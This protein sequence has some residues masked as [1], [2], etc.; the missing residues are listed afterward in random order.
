MK[1][2]IEAALAKLDPENKEH[3]TSTG[4]PR[5]EAVNAILNA[6]KEADQTTEITRQDIQGAAPGFTKDVLVEMLQHGEVV[7]P[8]ELETDKNEALEDETDE[9]ERHDE[10]GDEPDEITEIEQEESLEKVVA[11]PVELP[12]ELKAPKREIPDELYKKLTQELAACDALKARNLK[13]MEQMRLENVET[14]KRKA[15][16]QAERDRLF[17]PM[18]AAQA[19][20][21]YLKRQQEERIKRA[22]NVQNQAAI[23]QSVKSPIDQAMAHRRGLGKNRPNFNPVQTARK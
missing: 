4:L 16:I 21:V 13:A 12:E 22:Q 3:W 19:T 5:V 9:G 15:R 7:D 18:T 1:Q 11:D 6:D 20:Q 23:L 17:P 10:P 2:Q 14:D 8:D